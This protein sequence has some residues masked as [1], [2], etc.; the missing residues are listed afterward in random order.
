M[1]ILQRGWQIYSPALGWTNTGFLYP[2]C[3]RRE[4]IGLQW[5][6]WCNRIIGF[7]FSHP[8]HRRKQ[9]KELL[10]SGSTCWKMSVSIKWTQYSSFMTLNF[11]LM[12]NKF[13]LFGFQL[14]ILE[15]Y[16][17]HARTEESQNHWNQEVH[18]YSSRIT[19]Q[20]IQWKL[21][22]ARSIQL[23]FLIWSPHAI[24]HLEICCQTFWL[25][26]F[27]WYWV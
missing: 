15:L 9:R 8:L 21:R 4:K 11:V 1:C 16:L 26:T 5:L 3:Q 25:W 20:H 24:K 18:L 19:S 2:R 22:L 10:I 7:L 13:L 23:H 27:T 17:V 6:T 12:M 14:V